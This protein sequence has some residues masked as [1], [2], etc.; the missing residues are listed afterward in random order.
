[1]KKLAAKSV[2][3]TL[4]VGVNTLLLIV[5]LVGAP[6]ATSLDLGSIRLSNP[7]S[8]PLVLTGGLVVAIAFNLVAAT[9]CKKPKHRTTCLRWLLLHTTLLTATLAQIAGWIDFAWLKTLLLHLRQ[10]V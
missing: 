6:T 2:P 8:L 3:P 10:K 5:L 9:L 1:M 7:R 4:I